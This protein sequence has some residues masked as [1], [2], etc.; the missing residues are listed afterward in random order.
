MNNQVNLIESQVKLDE[1]SDGFIAQTMQIIPQEFI[2]EC[3]AERFHNSQ[4]RVNTEMH[5]AGRVPQVIVDK[6]MREG[7]NIFQEPVKKTLAKL[8]AEGL[9]Y[10]ITSDKA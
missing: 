4:T 8:K 2:D 5:R 3:K 7:Y 1:Y 6:W 9:D 10:F